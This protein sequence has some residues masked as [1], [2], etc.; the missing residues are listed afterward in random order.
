M[1]FNVIGLKKVKEKSPQ[2]SGHCHYD[3]IGLMVMGIDEMGFSASP[4]W[5]SDPKVLGALE[6]TVRWQ[7]R[8]PWRDRF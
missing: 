6:V 4:A 5:G 1:P 7:K 2:C 3:Q 8:S